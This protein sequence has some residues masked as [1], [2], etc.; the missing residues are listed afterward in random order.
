VKNST[1]IGTTVAEIS[2]TGQRKN[3]EL[4][5]LPC[6]IRMTGNNRSVFRPTQEI[7]GYIRH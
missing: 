6:H 5:T 4:S 2:V 7:L 3:S 1:P